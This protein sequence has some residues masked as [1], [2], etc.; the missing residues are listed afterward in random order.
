[1]VDDADDRAVEGA[2]RLLRVTPEEMAAI[3]D[4]QLGATVKA[5]EF[6]ERLPRTPRRGTWDDA[7]WLGF[8]EERVRPALARE[9]GRDSFDLDVMRA[10]VVR[11]KGALQ[12]YS[13]LCGCRVDGEERFVR[14]WGRQFATV[15]AAE[16]DLA[17]AEGTD[18]RVLFAS[19]ADRIL[20]EADLGQARLPE[21]MD[22]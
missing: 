2:T 15:E 8:R 4:G 17:E 6:L 10:T 7:V 19:P 14:L 20:I 9:L 18:R 22:C 13:L 11:E 12:M 21:L 16:R 3:H 5:A 1:V